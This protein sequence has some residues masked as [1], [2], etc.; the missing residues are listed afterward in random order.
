[1]NLDYIK[2]DF[3]MWMDKT[4]TGLL[5]PK[6]YFGCMIA[7]LIEQEPI[8]QDRIIALTGYSRTTIS[9]MLKMLQ[10][11]FPVTVIKKPG[12]RKKYF[13]IETGTREFMISFRMM[14]IN[15]YKD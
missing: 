5:F 3:V 14:I 1:M 4:H 12:S 9:Q 7:I 15:T 10:V 6:N 11:N 2:K 8:P 13:T